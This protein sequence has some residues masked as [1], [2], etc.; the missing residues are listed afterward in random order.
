MNHLPKTILKTNGFALG[1]S[2]KG[3]FKTEEGEIIKLILN[4]NTKPYLLLTKKNGEKIY[5]SDKASSNE[6]IYHKLKKA[7][8]NIVF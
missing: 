1:S 2:R 8:P 6:E 3:Y 4:S 5:F 7:F